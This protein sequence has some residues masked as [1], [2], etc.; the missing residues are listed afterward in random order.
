M[1]SDDDKV[2]I[3]KLAQAGC[4]VPFEQ[5]PPFARLLAFTQIAPLTS[6]Q[7]L[8]DLMDIWVPID[9]GERNGIYPA[10]LRVHHQAVR[11]SPALNLR[12]PLL[13]VD[14]ELSV[15]EIFGMLRQMCEHPGAS[16]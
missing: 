6:I 2:A 11:A 12:K 1:M 10:Q 8:A 7:S 15:A 13:P 5:Q 9:L 3:L 14:A 16:P 4:R